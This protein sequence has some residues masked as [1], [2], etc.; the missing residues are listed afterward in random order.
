MEEDRMLTDTELAEFSNQ[1]SE[2]KQM[3]DG[4]LTESNRTMESQ[5]RRH[6]EL[7]AQMQGQNESQ[8]RRHE[9]RMAQIRSMFESQNRMIG[10]HSPTSRPVS[11]HSQPTAISGSDCSFGTRSASAMQGSPWCWSSTPSGYLNMLESGFVCATASPLLGTSVLD[12]AIDAIPFLVPKP[13]QQVSDPGSLETKYDIVMSL[14]ETRI[15]GPRLLELTKKSE[16]EEMESPYLPVSIEKV[17]VHTVNGDDTHQEVEEKVIEEDVETLAEYKCVTHLA[18]SAQVLATKASV[19]GNQLN[20]PLLIIWSDYEYMD[21]YLNPPTDGLKILEIICTPTVCKNASADLT[22]QFAASLKLCCTSYNSVGFHGVDSKHIK[23]DKPPPLPLELEYGD[24]F[25][26]VWWKTFVSSDLVGLAYISNCYSKKCSVTCV[27]EY[28][29]VWLL[30]SHGLNSTLRLCMLGVHK[31]DFLKLIWLQKPPPWPPDVYMNN[32]TSQAIERAMIFEQMGVGKG[33]AKLIAGLSW[34][35]DYEIGDGTTETDW[36]DIN[37]ESIKIVRFGDQQNDGLLNVSLKME[38]CKCQGKHIPH[39]HGFGTLAWSWNAAKALP[40]KRES[41]VFWK[42]SLNVT[43]N[44]ETLDFES[45]LKLQ[46]SHAMPMIK[47]GPKPKVSLTQKILQG[48][49]KVF[50]FKLSSED[51]DGNEE[52]FEYRVVMKADKV[53]WD[54]QVFQCKVI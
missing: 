16:E 11:D 37:L 7:M 12:L 26:I 51:N 40:M 39:V 19:T 9:E 17:T 41:T 8:I 22:S 1:I 34:I 54:G 35:Q 10:G 6:E 33:I 3:V 50:V 29:K 45:L 38:N 18:S 28:A 20:I 4:Y 46:H 42:F 15:D 2:I 52:F 24:G 13:V 44:H 23:L 36:N 25:D 47:E 5:N 14:S 27:D 21:P 31:Y 30:P 32:A 49:S 48:D 43:P 53:S